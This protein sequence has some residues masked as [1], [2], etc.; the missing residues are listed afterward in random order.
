MLDGNDHSMTME[1][2]GRVTLIRA[3]KPERLWVQPAEGG[4]M[5]SL[6]LASCAETY[7]VLSER[8]KLEAR[9]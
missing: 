2:E 6:S 5:S 1:Q 4:T 9:L 8:M 3:S 7:V